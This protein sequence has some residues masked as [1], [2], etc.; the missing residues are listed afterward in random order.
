MGD[1]G[2]N[3]TFYFG[4]DQISIRRKDKKTTIEP[5]NNNNSAL[6]AYPNPCHDQLYIDGIEDGEIVNIYNLQG[7]MVMTQIVVNKN[8]PLQISSLSAG[9][10]V[11]K[12]KNKNRSI[13]LIKK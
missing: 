1:W 11:V 2:A 9:I 6:I 12:H 13:K 5:V 8:E 7:Q 3:T 10:Y 4:L